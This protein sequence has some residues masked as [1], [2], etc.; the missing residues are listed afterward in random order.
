MTGLQQDQIENKIREL[1]ALIEPYSHNREGL[2]DTPARVAAAYKE[3]FRG[4]ETGGKEIDA[5]LKTFPC[6]SSE[7]I[8]FTDVQFT[9]VCEHHMLPF[10][11]V[12]HVGYIPS[13]TVVGASKVP[14][15]VEVY[16]RRLQ[17]QE[18]MTTQIA[19]ALYSA[20]PLA[21]QGVGVVTRATHLCMTCRGVKQPTAGMVCSALRGVF[22][23]QEV[24]A[25][26]LNLVH[27]K[28]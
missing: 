6:L 22:T 11:G 16:A 20:K 9:S 25:E 17:I 28:V 14:R 27:Q 23:K 21:P 1:L 13:Q 18:Q 3:M 8:V 7:M 5:L 10:I 19:D 26:F 12:A 24:R 4:Y 2:R 15:L